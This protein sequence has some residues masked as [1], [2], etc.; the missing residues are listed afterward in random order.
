[1]VIVKSK[2]HI[3]IFLFNYIIL[4]LHCVFFFKKT[5]FLKVEYLFCQCLKNISKKEYRVDVR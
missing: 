3:W 4:C 2:T 1:M 5:F